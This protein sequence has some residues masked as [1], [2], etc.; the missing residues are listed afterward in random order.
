[1]L[2]LLGTGVH[3]RWRARRRPI[4]PPPL[5]VVGSLRSGGSCKTD[6]VA[7]IARRHPHLAVLVHPTGDEDRMLGEIFPGRVFAHRD[8]LRAWDEAR[9]SGFLAG[10]CDGGL[11]DPALD[12]C[13]AL[14][15]VHPE[16][17]RD[18]SDLL[19]F[20][21]FRAL[22][23]FPRAVERALLLGTDFRT[24][25]DPA[26]L[27]PPGTEVDAACAVARPEIFFRELEA[28]GLR[29]VERESLPDHAGFPDSLLRRMVDGIRPWLVTAKDASRAPLPKGARAVGRISELSPDSVVAVD[30]LVDL[31]PRNTPQSGVLESDPSIS[32]TSRGTR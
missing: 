4:D 11:Q 32:R 14:L 20:G 1:M 15:L 25:L 2:W 28:S 6:L 17:P 10:V 23:P 9:R 21:P 5:L 31:P 19:P 18:A 13:P 8:W 24:R 27:P 12:G 7:W 26:H 22:R 3:R 29:L 30:G 16:G